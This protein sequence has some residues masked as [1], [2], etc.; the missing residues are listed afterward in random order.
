MSD[1]KNVVF[2]VGDRGRDILINIKGSGGGGGGNCNLI[3]KTTQEWEET[4]S[5]V[6]NKKT[7]L[8]YSDAYHDGQGN[9]IPRVKIGDGET[10]IVDLPFA[11][12]DMPPGGFAGDLLAKTSDADYNATWITPA[13]SIEQDN[14]KPITAAAVYTE[15]GN[16][17]ALLAII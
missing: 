8:V 5:F 1:Y 13:N 10:T 7:I 11:G 9:P 2:D 16:I 14:T 17:N 3:T 15:I 12:N 4:P 6:P